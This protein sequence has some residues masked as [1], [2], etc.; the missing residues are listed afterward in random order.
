[1]TD[2]Y[3]L[4]TPWAFANDSVQGPSG[5]RTRLQIKFTNAPFRSDSSSH[6]HAIRDFKTKFGTVEQDS[7]FDEEIDGTPVEDEHLALKKEE[8]DDNISSAIVD[9]EDQAKKF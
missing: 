2:P 4:L 9:E 8:S 5:R 6:G 7:V 3:L 1:M